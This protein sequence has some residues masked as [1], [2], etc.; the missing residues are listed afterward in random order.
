M[1]F[2]KAL[3]RSI[4]VYIY[5]YEPLG[6]NILTGDNVVDGRLVPSSFSAKTRKSYSLSSIRQEIVIWF[7]IHT[8]VLILSQT[9][10]PISH[11]S[12]QK[13]MIGAPPSSLGLSQERLTKSSPTLDARGI[14]GGDGTSESSNI[15][16]A[17]YRG[18]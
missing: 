5:I 18:G 3:A 4:Y 13:P 14:P 12:I 7:V 2:K 11:F 1:G 15:A 8:V 10:E 16:L 9:N 6:S 17:V